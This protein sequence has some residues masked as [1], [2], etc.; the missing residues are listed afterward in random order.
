MVKQAFMVLEEW[1]A[2]RRLY[3]LVGYVIWAGVD[4]NE[5]LVLAVGATKHE[6]KEKVRA[7]VFRHAF[8]PTAPA[9]VTEEW[10]A[11]QLDG[12]TYSPGSRRI[13]SILLLFNLA[14]LLRNP[15]SNMR[16]QF[17]SFKTA[18]WDIEHVRSVAPDRP[19]TSKGQAEWLKR[20]LGYLES[21]H[22]APELRTDIQAFINLPPKETTDASFDVV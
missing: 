10:I 14:T 16:F 2:D 7:K 22:E 19:G 13:R 5:L 12:L 21:A 17:E 9:P 6:F 8:G 1:F 4:V 3:H 11:D 18:N 15:Q 20:C